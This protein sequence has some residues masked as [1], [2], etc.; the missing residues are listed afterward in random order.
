[1][2]RLPHV[3]A[4]WFD[5]VV[6]PDRNVELLLQIAVVVADEESANP[7]LVV[8]PA[9]E[10]ARDACAGAVARLAAEKVEREALLEMEQ[11]A[12]RDAR[13]AARKAAKKERRRGY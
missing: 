13:Y 12:E 10:R 1:V 4:A 3:G 8:V 7:V 5:P 11:K 6:G 2:R 9:L